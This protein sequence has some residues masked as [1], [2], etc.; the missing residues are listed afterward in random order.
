VPSETA[1]W[2]SVAACLCTTLIGLGLVRFA[3]TPL[4]PALIA[5]HWFTPGQ[6][7]YLGAAN[8]GGYLIGALAARRVAHIMGVR[9]SLRMFMV[10]A[11]ASLVACAHRAGFAWFLPWR[12]VSGIAGAGLMVLAAPSVLPLMPARHR[13]LAGGLI[14]LGIGIGVVFSGT[15]LP[16]LLRQGVASAWLVLALVGACLTIFAWIALPP[17]PPAKTS[18]AGTRARTSAALWALYAAYALSAMGQVPALLFMA[19]FV[20]RGLGAGVATGGRMWAVFGLG[21]LAGPLGA[22]FLADK[23]G[24]VTTLRTL[25]ISQLL[26]CAGLVVWPALPVVAAANFLLGAGV[27]AF[28]VL[29]LGRS[30]F[31]AGDEDEARR[32]AWSLAT[33]GYALGQVLGAYGFSYLFAHSDRYDVLF[34]CGGVFMVLGF[35]ASEFSRARAVS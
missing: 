19:D 11:T 22:G 17:D 12:L 28:V 24:F 27:P 7:V 35:A 14:F 1:V 30:Q 9:R 32:N 23:I 33:T 6:A 10:L 16:V 13:G 2:R 18:L 29:V 21:A 15:V 4:I 31:L 8:I 25:W 20:A 5:A 26:A 34:A 3:Y